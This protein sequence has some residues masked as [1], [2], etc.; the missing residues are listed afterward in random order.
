M[1]TQRSTSSATA[2]ASSS[3]DA[4]DNT[5][6]CVSLADVK[7]LVAL[8]ADPEV[9]GLY[10]GVAASS[11]FAVIAVVVSLLSLRV[12]RESARAATISAEAAQRANWLTEQRMLQEVRAHP[13]P[14]S[15]TGDQEQVSV[16]A[17]PVPDVRFSLDRKSKHAF[18]LR[19]VGTAVAEEVRIPPEGA[20]P[21]S[22]GLPESATLRPGESVEFLMIGTLG[23][24][25]PNEIYV[26]WKE[27]PEDD[28]LVLAVP[29]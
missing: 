23:N 28:P 19:N 3:S 26:T 25:V 13:V 21:V 14:T 6:A 16:E 7:H 8:A 11:L 10:V 29:N 18:V 12:Q 17:A 27:R 15:A 2:T 1:A 22:R 20:A 5:R 4:S 9:V 24:H